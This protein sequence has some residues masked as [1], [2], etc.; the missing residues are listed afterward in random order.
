MRAVI[1]MLEPRALFSANAPTF[2]LDAVIAISE[3]NVSKPSAPS[4]LDAKGSTTELAAVLTWQDHSGNEAGF[5]IQRKGYGQPDTSY[6]TVKTTAPNVT[7]WKDTSVGYDSAYT[8]RVRA[9]NSRGVSAW[10]NADNAWTIKQPVQVGVTDLHFVSYDPATT[11][12]RLQYTYDATK[13]PY[14][15]VKDGADTSVTD[16]DGNIY[17]P[18][19][20]VGTVATY[21]VK[22][23]NGVL[24][25]VET[26]TNGTVPND[27]PPPDPVPVTDGIKVPSGQSIP[28]IYDTPILLERGGTYHMSLWTVSTA[29]ALI[30][31]Y[32]DT[33]APAPVIVCDSSILFDLNAS[34]TLNNV[35]LKTNYSGA[36]GIVFDAADI[37]LNNVYF[38]GS[39]WG[40][41][42]KLDD[43]CHHLRVKGWGGDAI[44]QRHWLYDNGF[45]H[46]ADVVIDL[47]GG[48]LPGSRDENV[49]RL[50]GIDGFTI[51][52]GNIFAPPDPDT[53]K[54]WITIQASPSI[55]SKNVL[56]EDVT[57]QGP[58]GVGPIET[59]AGWQTGLVS[60]V[61]FRRV[62]GSSLSQMYVQEG[63]SGVRL[64][65]CDFHCKKSVISFKG[66]NTNISA[67]LPDVTVVDCDLTGDS[68]FV[69]SPTLGE[70]TTE[71]S[72]F[73]GK[74][75]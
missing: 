8:Y 37:T 30:D 21:Q 65:D 51:H 1:E 28:H 43:G 20:A 70:V 53:Q 49:I 10:S 41:A 25:N 22:D 48:T 27:Q 11:R 71:N 64:E 63:A 26:Y 50:K 12:V 19:Q 73:N 44:I 61:I 56:V 52:N 2:D 60:N 47:D 45:G 74:A 68:S 7:S 29:G 16:T 38:S 4:N 72:T 14:T 3:L 54:S 46:N 13:G 18:A 36:T 34:F 33:S 32:G 40:D 6:T 31:C 59:T 67:P 62:H 15:L 17:T 35:T 69:S 23:A 39:N 66:G 75:I 57:A 42:F 5:R 24:S 58:Y 9:E 55:G